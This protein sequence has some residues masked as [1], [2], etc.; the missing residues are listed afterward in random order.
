[1]EQTLRI[2]NG[3]AWRAGVF[4]ATPLTARVSRGLRSSSFQQ[5]YQFVFG[6]GAQSGMSSSVVSMPWA[7]G[8]VEV[9]SVVRAATSIPA[10]TSPGGLGGHSRASSRPQ[11]PN[12]DS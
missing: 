12:F 2:V 7:S 1:I 11:S 6:Y 4:W 9:A 5:A 8:D 10:L 3:K